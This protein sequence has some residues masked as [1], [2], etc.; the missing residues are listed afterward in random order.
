MGYKEI[1]YSIEKGNIAVITINRPEAR[2]ALTHIT[3]TE[4]AQAIEQ[5]DKDDSVRV[6]VLTG[7]G[8]GFCAGDDVKVLFKSGEGY[9]DEGLQGKKQILNFLQDGRSAGGGG[10]LLTTN[11]PSIAAVNGAAVG[12]GCDMALMCDMRIASET[13]RFGEAFLRVGLIPNQALLILPRLV[14]LA[15]AYELV[16]TT[17]IIDA[18]EAYRIGLVNKVVPQADLMKATME[19]AMKLAN[20]PP[21][22]VKLAKAGIRKGLNIP[23]DEFLQWESLA[24]AY[25]TET[26][27]HKEGAKAFVEKRE[28]K[29][30]GK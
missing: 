4:L 14:G 28:P 27:D 29:F 25:C 22:S 10:P 23:L 19:L 17:D 21:I 26:E 18:Q 6:I 1:L 5:A 20:K 11:K 12:Y 24:F 16:L 15:K 7:T 13:A 3:H 9:G 8:Q 2:N 30:L